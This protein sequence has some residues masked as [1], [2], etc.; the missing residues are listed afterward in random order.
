M[1]VS[2]FPEPVCAPPDAWRECWRNTGGQSRWVSVNRHSVPPNFD[3]QNPQVPGRRVPSPEKQSTFK[4]PAAET[5]PREFGPEQP[6]NEPRFHTP[7]VR[8]RKPWKVGEDLVI[9]PPRALPAPVLWAYRAS[10]AI[11]R[12]VIMASVAFLFVIAGFAGW[13]VWGSNWYT[14]RQQAALSEQLQTSAA[15]TVKLPEESA[16]AT[17]KTKETVERLTNPE[18]KLLIDYVKSKDGT[19]MGR[20]TIDRIGVDETFVYGTSLEELKGGPGLWKWGVLPGQ[21]GTAMI[22]GHRSTWGKPFQKIDQLKKGDKIRIEIPDQ[23]DIVYEVRGTKIVQP[24]D[25]SVSDQVEG[26]RLTLTACHPYGSAAQRIV[27][28][29]ELIEGPATA[30][31]VPEEDWEFHV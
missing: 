3:P 2:A 15:P 7:R 19:P 24:S 1:G 13:E 16:K 27:V 8:D 4:L 12:R 17:A 10:L 18:S 30:Y 14:A 5:L 28:Q 21:P 6:L 9:P 11:A 26:A 23:P 22:S 20:I 29:A 25:V 31:A